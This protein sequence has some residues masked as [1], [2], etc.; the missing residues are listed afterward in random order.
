LVGEVADQLALR[1]NPFV[2]VKTG[3]MLGRSA[4]FSAQLDASLKEIV[5]FAQNG[6]LRIS[7]AEAAALTAKY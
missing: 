3:G 5:P 6:N 2:L 7:P 1:K 4:F